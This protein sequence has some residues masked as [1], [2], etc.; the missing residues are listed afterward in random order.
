M[1]YALIPAKSESRRVKNKNFVRISGKTLFEITLDF[2][3]ESE[4]FDKIIVSSD[5]RMGSLMHS[6]VVFDLRPKRLAK[7]TTTMDLLI[8]YM[9]KKYKMKNDDVIILLQPTS[10]LRSKNDLKEALFLFSE[11]KKTVIS[12]EKIENKEHMFFSSEDGLILIPYKN[13]YRQN[14]AFYI[15]NVKDFLKNRKIPVDFEPYQME[16]VNSID[17]DEYL[18][19]I[20]SLLV[21]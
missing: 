21:I 6:K 7:A 2:A 14:G 17:I 18:D 20:I 16:R 9:I 1:I 12:V 11:K 5:K 3:I 8:L 15:F 4:I 19:Y 13:I 10:P